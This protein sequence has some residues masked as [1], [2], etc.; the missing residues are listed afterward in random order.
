MALRKTSSPSVDVGAVEAVDVRQ[1]TLPAA[2]DWVDA[3][4]LPR[5][6]GMAAR[7]AQV[8]ADAAPDE[9]VRAALKRFASATD[10]S[11]QDAGDGSAHAWEGAVAAPHLVRAD[12]ADGRHLDDAGLYEPELAARTVAPLKKGL[13]QERVGQGRLKGQAQSLARVQAARA[14]SAAR[15]LAAT[16]VAK[17][18][19]LSPQRSLAGLQT[20]KVSLS[21]RAKDRLLGHCSVSQQ[22]CS[23]VKTSRS[24]QAQGS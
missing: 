4:S 21:Q 24:V 5:V 17:A 12:G 19:R 18:A 23:L 8:V 14:V 7:K 6:P 20:F 1:R 13:A 9:Q 10:C 22:Y 3:A 16:K 11:A 2:L 15:S